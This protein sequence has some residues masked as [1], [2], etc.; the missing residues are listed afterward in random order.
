MEA[1]IINV[2]QPDMEVLTPKKLKYIGIEDKGIKPIM[3]ANKNLYF[4]FFPL[5]IYSHIP[6]PERNR[7]P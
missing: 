6:Q 5:Q 3:G 2:I 1:K 7:V 4:W